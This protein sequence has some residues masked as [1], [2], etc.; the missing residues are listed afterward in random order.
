[1]D[2]VA[3]TWSVLAGVSFN[4]VQCH[5]HPYDPIRHSEYYKFLAF[6]NT[7]R[8][9]DIAFDA[10][11]EDGGQK[12]LLQARIFQAMALVTDIQTRQFNLCHHTAAC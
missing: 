2:R 3:T 12:S 6:F 7:S 1:M 4:C 11:L 5:S 9:A 10:A 8:D